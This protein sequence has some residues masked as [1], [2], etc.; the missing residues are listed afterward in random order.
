MA[1]RPEGV[2]IEAT[3][4]RWAKSAHQWLSAGALAGEGGG[5]RIVRVKRLFATSLARVTNRRR[6]RSPVFGDDASDA[7]EQTA[8]DFARRLEQLV[9]RIDE[10][11][12]GKS[13][14]LPSTCVESSQ[15]KEEP[16]ERRLAADAAS[17]A[18]KRIAC[19]AFLM[20]NRENPRFHDVSLHEFCIFMDAL[21][22]C[23]L[24]RESVCQDAT[25]AEQEKRLELVA[26]QVELL[27]E[28]TFA[29]ARELASVIASSRGGDVTPTV[30]PRHEG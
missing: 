13:K 7:S 20:N 16:T 19:C 29:L 18:A 11:V 4:G 22:H 2:P 10:A 24:L 26:T 25:H 30:H 5:D 17:S 27:S 28:S 1:G 9:M 23:H 8:A 6:S 15:S 14:R 21:E 3:L 12:A